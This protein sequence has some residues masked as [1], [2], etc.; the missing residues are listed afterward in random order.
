MHTLFCLNVFFLFFLILPCHFT[1][2]TKSERCLCC[3]SMWHSFSA[4]HS[5]GP[6]R[7]SWRAYIRTDMGAVVGPTHQY[8]TGAASRVSVMWRLP[9][10]MVKCIISHTMLQSTIL[11]MQIR[12]EVH[13]AW[14]ECQ[15][16][17]TCTL[18]VLAVLLLGRSR[19]DGS[20]CT[21]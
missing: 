20:E 3:Q 18:L 15:V 11:R 9:S 4:I 12:Q 7:N 17:W 6:G 2:S 1:F 21:T 13:V 19:N 14:W 16:K 5:A 10:R 8:A